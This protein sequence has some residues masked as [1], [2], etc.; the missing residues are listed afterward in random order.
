MHTHT[1]MLEACG[2]FTI[3]TCLG[4]IYAYMFVGGVRGLMCGMGLV[5]YVGVRGLYVGCGC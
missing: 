4:M 3:H 1:Y 5:D 2:L